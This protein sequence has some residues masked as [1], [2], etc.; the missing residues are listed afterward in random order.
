MKKISLCVMGFVFLGTAASAN[1]MNYTD[2]STTQ[3]PP[4]YNICYDGV[5]EVTTVTY[6]CAN[7]SGVS[8]GFANGW[9]FYYGANG[10]YV[11]GRQGQVLD[12]S[13][14]SRV[15]AEEIR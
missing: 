4:E 15:S 8:R 1:C 5:C 3:A 10:E 13:D 2:G 14:H 7:Q 11:V 9:E 12:E 6:E